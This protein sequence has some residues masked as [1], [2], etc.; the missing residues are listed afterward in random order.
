LGEIK[1]SYFK[2]LVLLLGF[3]L[4]CFSG[5]GTS[6]VASAGC[7]DTS[8][9]ERPL[10]RQFGSEEAYH[11]VYD[12]VLLR[13]EPHQELRE[14]HDSFMPRGQALILDLGGGTGL[15][16]RHLKESDPR[17]RIE[18]FDQSE[19][20]MEVAVEKGWPRENAHRSNMLNPTRTDGRV[21]EDGTVD[22]IVT[23]NALYI[24]SRKEVTELF[25]KA[26]RLLKR[27]GRFTPASMK[28]VSAEKMGEFLTFLKRRVL[29]LEE[30]GEVAQGASEI[31]F[32]TNRT[33]TQDSPTTFK[34]HEVVEIGESMGF[35]AIYQSGSPYR[36]AA[37]FVAFEKK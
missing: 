12:E 24:L 6:T 34:L 26:H 35:R 33:L 29:E 32:N 11:R 15:V 13:F 3:G 21:V 22:G 20:M 16:A 23:N 27:G 37:F 14:L 5:F 18:I 4:G 7:L 30:R 8:R 1:V 9:Q 17:R 25:A 19:A 2:G 36:G 28:D 10:E 31:F